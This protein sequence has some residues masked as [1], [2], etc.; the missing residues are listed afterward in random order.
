MTCVQHRTGKSPRHPQRTALIQDDYGRP[1]LGTS[2]MPAPPL[3]RRSSRDPVPAR[4]ATST[5]VGDA[6]PHADATA[7]AV[8]ATPQLATD[9]IVSHGGF[10][11]VLPRELDRRGR[12]S[13]CPLWTSLSSVGGRIPERPGG[14]RSHFARSDRPERQASGRLDSSLVRA[15]DARLAPSRGGECRTPRT[16]RGRTRRRGRTSPQ[17]EPRSGPLATRV[18][19]LS[20]RA[21]RRAARSQRSPGGRT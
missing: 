1:G 21:T 10:G 8:A 2:R 12:A 11:R 13:R 5:K 6:P 20:S 7:R 9:A 4:P 16:W 3:L 14:T 15:Q 19:A 17:S 18:R